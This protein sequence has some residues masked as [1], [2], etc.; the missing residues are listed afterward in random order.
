MNTSRSSSDLR[1]INRGSVLKAVAAGGTVSRHS[2][3]E[4]TG[5]TTA[6]ISRITRQLLDAGMLTETTGT[7][8]TVGRGRRT[9]GLRL[10]D[11]GAYLV[12]MVISANRRAVAITNSNGVLLVCKELSTVSL[13]P[14]QT[15]IYRFCQTA[16]E[17]IAQL[18]LPASRVL[19]VS[20]VVATNNNP[21]I[22]QKLSS[23]V[24]EWYNVDLKTPIAMEM[25]LPVHLEARSVALLQAEIWKNRLTKN[26]GSVFLVNN[27]WRLGSSV[28]VNNELLETEKYRLG[29]IAHLVLPASDKSCYCGDTGCL[30]ALVSGEAIVKTLEDAG[31]AIGAASTPPIQKLVTAIQLAE[32]N[33]NAASVFR[34]AGQHLGAG[35]NTV[36]ALFSPKR[37]FLA[38][39][40]AR[41]ADYVQGVMEI[42]NSRV[43]CKLLT[44]TA[45]SLEAAART[46]LNT[47]VFSEAFNLQQLEQAP[48]S[49]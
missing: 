39:A 42:F 4:Q 36:A 32:K 11:N 41:Q 12:V 14:A 19:G 1:V 49:A 23:D 2:L 38:G 13:T 34:L 27:G 17:L 47:F 24:L 31:F 18:S 6:A 9:S 44:S 28:F 15:A 5:L 48:L 10:S 29:Q 30:D 8:S 40:I 43:D 26:S 35:L 33:E 22:H 21:S 45:D 16:K 37:I 46:G 3:A 20:V 7:S 25:A